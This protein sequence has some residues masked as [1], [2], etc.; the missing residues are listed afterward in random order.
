MV[1]LLKFQIVKNLVKTRSVRKRRESLGGARLFSNVVHQNREE[2]HQLF[3]MDSSVCR[4]CRRISVG[5]IGTPDVATSYFILLLKTTGCP[6][7]FAILLPQFAEWHS[8]YGTSHFS[9]HFYIS[10]FYSGSLQYT[11]ETVGFVE[12]YFKVKHRLVFFHSNFSILFPKIFTIIDLI[13]EKMSLE[14]QNK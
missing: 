11:T 5:A 2:G 3:G 10:I 8:R 1:S 4:R 12:Q 7:R 13:H 14:K 9:R 6:E